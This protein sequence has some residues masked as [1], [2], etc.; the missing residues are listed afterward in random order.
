MDN[1]I[2]NI[3]IPKSNTT[4]PLQGGASDVNKTIRETALLQ[5]L[6][7]ARDRYLPIYLCDYLLPPLPAIV[8]CLLATS[9]VWCTALHVAL[10]FTSAPS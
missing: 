1:D 5:R 3:G 10:P 4:D 9:V 6:C 2:L 7:L 8:A